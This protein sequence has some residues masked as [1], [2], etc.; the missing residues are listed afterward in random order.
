MYLQSEASSKN[1]SGQSKE[2]Y[3]QRKEDC[4]E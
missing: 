2:R 3:P 1:S 4:C